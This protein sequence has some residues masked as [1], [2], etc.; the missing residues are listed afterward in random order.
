VCVVDV[1][2]QPGYDTPMSGSSASQKR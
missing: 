2:V 1:R